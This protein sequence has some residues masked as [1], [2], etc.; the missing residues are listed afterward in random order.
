MDLSKRNI[1]LNGFKPKKAKKKSNANHGAPPAESVKYLS[2]K[3][4]ASK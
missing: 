3:V 2:R 1:S 4:D